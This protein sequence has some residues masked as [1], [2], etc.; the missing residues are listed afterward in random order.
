M[1]NNPNP[2]RPKMTRISSAEVRDLLR[3]RTH[4]QHLIYSMEHDRSLNAEVQKVATLRNLLR[5]IEE[6]INT[7]LTITGGEGRY[8]KPY[9]QPRY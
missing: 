8:D 4:L 2:V 3:S 5:G 1:S 7:T 9:S 6:Q